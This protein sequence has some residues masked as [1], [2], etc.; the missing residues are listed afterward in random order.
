MW[1]MA[2]RRGLLAGCVGAAVVAGLLAYTSAWTAWCAAAGWGRIGDAW[3]RA[4]SFVIGVAAL[5]SALSVAVGLLD[6]AAGWT[7]LVPGL[8]LAALWIAALWHLSIAAR[9]VKAALDQ[10]G[11]PTQQPVR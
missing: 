2:E 1:V 9:S 5:A 6:G 8:A 4:R 7:W 3:R 10:A 11:S